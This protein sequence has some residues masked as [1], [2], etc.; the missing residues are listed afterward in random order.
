ML[1]L[2]PP[3]KNRPI[4]AFFLVFPSSSRQLLPRLLLLLLPQILGFIQKTISFFSMAFRKI[5]KLLVRSIFSALRTLFDQVTKPERPLDMMHLAVT[6]TTEGHHVGFIVGTAVNDRNVMV[7]L[8][9]SGV[10]FPA[11]NAK[12]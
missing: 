2:R 10:T 12:L 8:Q 5:L 4:S 11:K 3:A 7:V 1:L 6:Q 9:R